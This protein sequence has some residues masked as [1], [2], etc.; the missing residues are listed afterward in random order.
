MDGEG[1]GAME[2]GN[3]AG[4]EGARAAG[5]IANG[6]PEPE[7][8]FW[9]ETVAHCRTALALVTG[10]LA[11]QVE[12]GEIPEPLLEELRRAETLLNRAIEKLANLSAVKV[13]A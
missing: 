12:E 9:H 5:A 11:A 8:R 10:R 6:L 4:R 3:G 13:I 2:E 1:E 7:D